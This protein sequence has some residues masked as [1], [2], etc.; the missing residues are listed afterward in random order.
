MLFRSDD[1][2]GLAVP[3]TAGAGLRVRV[4]DWVAVALEAQ[5]ELGAGLFSRGLGL[6]PQAGLAIGAAVEFALP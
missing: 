1:V 2:T 6:E 3:L 4:I 5:L